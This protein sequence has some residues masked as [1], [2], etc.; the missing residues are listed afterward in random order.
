MDYR[1]EWMNQKLCTYLGL[2]PSGNYFE[3]MLLA[4]DDLDYALQQFVDDE[5]LTWDRERTLFHV[6]KTSYDKLVEKEIL[7]PEIGEL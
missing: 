5:L 1:R 3:E 6:Y 7:V 2:D 4:D